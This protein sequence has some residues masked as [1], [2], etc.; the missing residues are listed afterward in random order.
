MKTRWCAIGVVMLMAGVATG[1]VLACGDKFLVPGRAVRF[2]LTPAARQQVAVLLFVNP[3]SAL[4]AVF[5]KLAVD[6]ALRKAGY[7]PT[8]V[9]TADGLGRTL[10]QGGWDVVL[11]DLADGTAME[12]LSAAGASAPAVLAVALK[13][14]DSDL[15]RAKKLYAVVLKSPTRSQSFVEA[16][17]VT[18]ATR[19]AAQAKQ[20]KQAK[21]SH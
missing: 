10:Q 17:D 12:N 8:V 2:E 6:P 4:P 19:R 7:Q 11:L 15:A 16:I 20:A 9:T 14:T 1:D 5:T 3:A 18:I 13:A 21:G